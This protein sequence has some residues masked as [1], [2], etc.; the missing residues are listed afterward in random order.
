MA[1]RAVPQVGHLRLAPAQLRVASKNHGTATGSPY[2]EA[3]VRVAV[4]V[5][6]VVVIIAIVVVVVV[7]GAP[8]LPTMLVDISTTR[9]LG[10]GGRGGK[11]RIIAYKPTSTSQLSFKFYD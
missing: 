3:G 2:R 9:A 5:V 1:Q 7:V 11:G 8:P 10:G 6:V 4:V